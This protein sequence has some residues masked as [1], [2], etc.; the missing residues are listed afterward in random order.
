M[1]SHKPSMFMKLRTTHSIRLAVATASLAA[2]FVSSL[3]SQAA[4]LPPSG[5]GTPAG[6]IYFRAGSGESAHAYSMKADGSQKTALGVGYGSPSA[7]A[8]GG[9][10]WFL[11]RREI[12][13]QN[14][15]GGFPRK[16]LFA[17][18]EDGAI[19]VQ[20][21]DNPA[22]TFY[23]ID[24]TPAENATEAILAGVGWRW[25]PDGTKEAGSVG[26]HSATLRFDADGNVTGLDMPPAFL[27]SVGTIED[28]IYGE[29]PFPDI[30]GKLSFSPDMS[31]LVVDHLESTV[32]GL[33]IRIIDVATGTE[34]PLVSGRSRE[35]MWSPDGTKISFV[36]LSSEY[37]IEVMA[38]NGTGRIKVYRTS[39][40]A[41]YPPIWSPDSAHLAF[42]YYSTTISDIYRVPASGGSAANLTKDI[43][44]GVGGLGWR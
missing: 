43:S 19:T 23:Y 14:D 29:G 38:P 25:N 40:D 13:G 3:S 33:G 22:A 2:F 37:A 18:R 31:K 20:L 44:A 16:E 21:T 4:K 42:T 36:T 1:K 26:V 41:I 8:H 27:L 15:L 32:Y 17:V 11:Q 34:T 5:S 28:A 39:R 35:P 12:V 6:T 24:W 30:D 10:R 9:K 7:L